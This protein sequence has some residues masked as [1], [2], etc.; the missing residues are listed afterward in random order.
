MCVCV[1]WGGGHVVFGALYQAPNH[2]EPAHAR[3]IANHSVQNLLLPLRG[4]G[5]DGLGS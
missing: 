1:G 3:N 4:L 2:I 5:T